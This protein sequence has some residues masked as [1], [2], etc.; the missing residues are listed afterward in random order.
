M[1]KKG[2]AC[3]G[4]WSEY[5]QQFFE[6]ARLPDCPVSVINPYQHLAETS[7]S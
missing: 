3:I 4:F 1:A 6:N 5:D 2:I 7:I